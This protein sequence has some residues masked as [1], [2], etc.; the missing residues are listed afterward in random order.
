MEPSRAEMWAYARSVRE[1]I[2][3]L[4]ASAGELTALV[5][6]FERNKKCLAEAVEVALESAQAHV[7]RL[8]NRLTD[9]L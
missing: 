6:R 7:Q 9:P 5:E 3:A 4:R 8:T 2:E 1:G